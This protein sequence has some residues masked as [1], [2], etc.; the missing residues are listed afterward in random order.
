MDDLNLELVELT[1]SK[2]S[3]LILQPRLM[4]C[5]VEFQK[6]DPNLKKV[7][8]RVSDRPNEDFQ[9]SGD[10]S[11]R[12]RSRFC[13]FDDEKLKKDVLRDAHNIKYSIH[14]RNTKRGRDLKQLF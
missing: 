6:L 5:I 8:I 13:V 11:I 4:D 1:T 10:R 3:A 7:R 14:A 12:M 2:L 9:I